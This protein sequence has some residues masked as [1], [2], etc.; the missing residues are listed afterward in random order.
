MKG[1]GAE[2]IGACSTSSG[3]H[4]QREE[5]EHMFFDTQLCIL[6]PSAVSAKDG[7][8]A[9]RRVAQHAFDDCDGVDLRQLLR[10]LAGE[11]HRRGGGWVSGAPS[12]G[13]EGLHNAG[14]G[15]GRV[16]AGGLADAGGVDASG[17]VLFPVNLCERPISKRSLVYEY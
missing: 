13:G 14:G 11:L 7:H 16:S 12:G 15:V 4:R 6:V 3:T 1:A 9:D 2:E 5:T 8:T 17:G 10:G